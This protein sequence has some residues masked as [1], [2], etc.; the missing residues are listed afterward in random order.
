MT[1]REECVEWLTTWDIVDKQPEQ[2]CTDLSTLQSLV[3]LVQSKMA[4]TRAEA[5][6]EGYGQGLDY[7]HWEATPDDR[8]GHDKPVNPY[9]KDSKPS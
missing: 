4:E 5:W 9:K 3:Q 7:G 2:G 6:H 8:N 1:L